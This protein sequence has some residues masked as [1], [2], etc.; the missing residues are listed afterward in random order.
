[1]RKIIYITLLVL[2]PMVA[3]ADLLEDILRGEYNAET[4]SAHEMDSVLNPATGEEGLRYQLRYE[5]EKRLFRHSFEA[6]YYLWDTKRQERVKMTEGAVRDAVMSPNG[7]Y[8]VYFKQ[9]NLYIYKTDYKT[10]VAMTRE[11]YN[12]DGDYVGSEIYSGVSD[13]LYEEEFGITTMFAFSPDN[14]YVAFIRLDETDVPTMTWQNYLEKNDYPTEES[15]RYPKAGQKNATATLCVYD[16]YYKSIKTMQLPELKDAYLPRLRWTNLQEGKGSEVLVQRLNRDQNKM[17]IYACNPASTVCSLL[18]KEEMK[19]YFVDYEQF[20]AWCWLKDNRFVA[21]NEQSGWRAAYLYS[22]QGQKIRQLT[23]NGVDVTAIYGMD[24]QAGV[25]YYQAAAT[26]ETRHAYALNMKKGTV[27]QLTQEDGTHDLTFSK[28]MKQYIDCYQSEEI[29]N[30]YTLYTAAGK[31]VKELKNNNDLQKRWEALD[32]PAKKFGTFVT[33][34]GDTL[35][36]WWLEPETQHNMP[37]VMTQYSGPCSQRVLNRWRK[38]FEY[39]LAAQG[40]V[41]A[42]VDPR[43]TDCRGTNFRKQTYMELGHKEAEDQLSFA[44]YIAQD[45]GVKKGVVNPERIGMI[46]WSYGGFQVIRTLSEQGMMMEKG[47]LSKPVIKAGVAIAP[48]TDWRLYDSAY[49]ERYMRRP[50]VNESGYKASDLSTMA[51]DLQG[52]LLI[53]HGMSDDNVHAQHTLRYV[54][55]LVEAGK[56]FEMQVYP[57]DNHFLKKRSNYLHVHKRLLRFLEQKM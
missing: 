43:G 53:M 51:K 44:Q 48:V 21:V 24:E 23:P 55:A 4:M 45:W 36:Y 26:P 11:G 38:R 56:Q 49:T 46:G 42:C 9:G 13:W 15:L 54:D 35:H 29:P 12:I 7:K 6:E 18:Y 52:E 14:K 31:K 57:D 25:L 17:E 16:I 33:E 28:D 5:N 20:D 1:M 47:R 8:V 34:R 41:V 32:L 37:C 50:Q 30:R 22:A 19:D 2:L 3:Q 27:Q 10:E 40:Y 39:A